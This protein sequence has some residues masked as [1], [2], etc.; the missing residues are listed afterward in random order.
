MVTATGLAQDLDQILDIRGSDDT[1]SNLMDDINRNHLY[2]SRQESIP[3]NS[4]VDIGFRLLREYILSRTAQI[5]LTF[6][7]F[8]S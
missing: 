8:S 3:Q 5:V 7:F 6:L 1:Y 2:Y 4:P